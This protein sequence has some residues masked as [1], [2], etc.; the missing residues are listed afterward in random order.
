M[1]G[2]GW[3]SRGC[4][5]GW[6]W[7]EEGWG[8][9]KWPEQNQCLCGPRGVGPQDPLWHLEVRLGPPPGDHEHQGAAPPASPDR[10]SNSALTP[11]PERSAAVVAEQEGERGPPQPQPV[12]QRR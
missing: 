8:D 2:F 3:G 11:C 7:G 4:I 10:A 5:W 6:G 12:D 9:Q 1:W